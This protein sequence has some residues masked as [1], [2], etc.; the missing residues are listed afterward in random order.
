MKQVNVAIIGG[1]FM[2]KAHSNAWRQVVHFFPNVRLKPVMK[3]LCALPAEAAKKAA[4][5]FGW[6]EYSDDW[7]AVVR[8][9]DIDIVDICTPGNLHKVMAV[10]A[11]RQGKHVICEKPLANTVAEARA[12]VDAVRK[13]GVVNMCAFN[14][15]RVPAVA[16]A[17]RLIEEGRIGRIYHFRAFYQQD[18]IMDPQFP[19]VW[20]LRKEVAGSGALGDIGAHIA[21]LA[22]YL[23]GEVTEV[24]GMMETFIKERPLGEM[25]GG[26]KAKGKGGKGKVTVDD[27]VA[28]LA[29][30][31]NGALG[32]FEATRFAAGRKNR[33]GF[34]LYGERGAICFDFE[35]M[36]RLQFFSTKDPAHAQGFRNILVTEPVHDYIGAWWPAGH[37]IGYEHTF[38]HEIYDFLNAVAAR[39]SVKPSFEDGLAIQ[40]ILAAVEKSAAT[41]K[42]VK[43]N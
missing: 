32:T 10:E 31:E 34:E 24:C 21:D 15:R 14:Y 33:N 37:I 36:N 43:V 22:R 13:A 20:R 27:A 18:W 3:V 9:K 30:F 4:E 1:Q 29:R 28:W 38:V 35:D 2:G 12:M 11:A 40:K 16:L 25:A 41:R 6:E 17:K 23:V 42:W 19:L 8:R 26:L 5:Q 39:K 7:K